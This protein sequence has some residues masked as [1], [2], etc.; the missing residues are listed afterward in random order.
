MSIE[1]PVHLA[2][3]DYRDSEQI[4]KYVFAMNQ[5]KEMNNL[6]TVIETKVLVLTEL[7]NVDEIALATKEL[8]ELRSEACLKTAQVD[9]LIK[10]LLPNP[11]VAEQP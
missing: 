6:W 11:P 9:T 1:Q 4:K 7:K 3:F 8:E 10:G 2:D 5:M